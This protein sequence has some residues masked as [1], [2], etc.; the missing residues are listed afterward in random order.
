M[1]PLSDFTDRDPML[2]QSQAAHSQPQFSI[3]A[4]A[5]NQGYVTQGK[6]RVD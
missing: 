3:E 2:Y 5:G 1:H 4:R 6:R